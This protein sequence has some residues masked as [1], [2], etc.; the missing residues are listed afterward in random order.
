[1][2]YTGPPEDCDDTT[3]DSTRRRPWREPGSPQDWRERVREGF[4]HASPHLKGFESFRDMWAI[5]MDLGTLMNATTHRVEYSPAKRRG[6]AAEAGS[7]L[8]RSP[9]ICEFIPFSNQRGREAVKLLL[10]SGFAIEERKASQGRAPLYHLVVPIT[11][12]F[13]ISAVLATAEALG[14]TPARRSR[15]TTPLTQR[16]RLYAEIRRSGQDPAEVFGDLYGSA[17]TGPSSRSSEPHRH[18]GPQEDRHHSPQEDRPDGPSSTTGVRE[19]VRAEVD[20][21]GTTPREHTGSKRRTGAGG[22]METVPGGRLNE[23]P[24]DVWLPMRDGGRR[25]AHG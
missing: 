17:L 22:I 4:F 21:T 3:P 15:N 25:R 6:R 19:T 10:A 9:G 1:M 8:Y 16:R 13:D 24:D 14:L 5:A 12:L 23:R 11:G 2:P 18:H 20:Q 7:G